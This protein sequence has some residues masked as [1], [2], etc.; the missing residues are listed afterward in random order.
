GRGR[1]F[2]PCSAHQP[3]PTL[4][5]SQH[6][7]AKTGVSALIS[8]TR[9]GAAMAGEPLCRGLIDRAKQLSLRAALPAG[10][11]CRLVDEEIVALGASFDRGGHPARLRAATRPSIALAV[12]ILRRNLSPLQR[13]ATASR[14][15]RNDQP[16][17][18]QSRKLLLQLIGPAAEHSADVIAQL[19]ERLD[20]HRGQVL[21]RHSAL[22]RENGC[23]D[24][25]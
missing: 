1:R 10:F 8:S 20:R 12:A 7:P 24:L 19:Q 15:C 6:K 22:Q 11:L 23:N 4:A 13:P 18:A 16:A 25:A 2:N 3:S 21:F 9:Y 5:R 14:P 17:V